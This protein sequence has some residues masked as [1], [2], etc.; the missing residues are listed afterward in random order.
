MFYKVSP[1]QEALIILTDIRIRHHSRGA[2]YSK[3]TIED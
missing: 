1:P 2:F 3:V